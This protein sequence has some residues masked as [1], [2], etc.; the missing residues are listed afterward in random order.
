ML[1]RSLREPLRRPLFRRL[2]ATYAV[3]ELGDWMG[4]IAL[5]VLVFDQTGSA[6]ATAALFIGTHFLPALLVPLLVARAEQPPP[7][8]ALPLIYCGE[9]AAFG[10]LALLATNF[11]LAGVI[12]LAAS[13]GPW[14]SAAG[15]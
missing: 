13:T 2:A 14:P 12:V 4:M 7:R 8:I 5:S 6:L 15:P 3:N 9:A 10:G 1:D 11:S